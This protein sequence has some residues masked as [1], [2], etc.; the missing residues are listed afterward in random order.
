MNFLIYAI[1]TVPDTET[2]ARKY[3][4]GDLDD[5]SALKAIMH[6]HQQSGKDEL[7]HYMQRIVAISTIFRGEGVTLEVNSFG[8]DTSANTSAVNMDPEAHMIN[9]F[10]KSINTYKIPTLISWDSIGNDMPILMYRCLKHKIPATLLT[11]SH[12]L[13]LAHA[14][15]NYQDEAATSVENIMTLL[16]LDYVSALTT[17]EVWKHWGKSNSELIK[18]NCTF[19]VL[20]SY[21]VYLR[22]QLMIGEVTHQHFEHEAIRI[23]RLMSE[24]MS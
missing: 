4:L 2:G 15:S 11:S 16:G 3:N 6:L 5:K 17:K 24:R 20:N 18:E 1:H 19:K 12:P 21:R 10:F 22:Y 9:Q 23:E 8:A 13:S 14:I 7:P